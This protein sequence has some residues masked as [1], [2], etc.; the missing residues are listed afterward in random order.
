NAKVREQDR[1]PERMKWR[2]S[3][4]LARRRK[5]FAGLLLTAAN[6]ARPPNLA[7]GVGSD[8]TP[9]ME[10]AQTRIPISRFGVRSVFHPWLGDLASLPT[11]PGVAKNSD[12]LRS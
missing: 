7:G 11:F 6:R 12:G 2:S 8:E 3:G 4:G 1:Q 9:R 5:P 10:P